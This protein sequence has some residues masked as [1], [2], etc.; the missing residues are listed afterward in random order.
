MLE[1]DVAGAETHETE[2]K[3]SDGVLAKGKPFV[4][5]GFAEGFR[6]L[7]VWLRNSV[8]KL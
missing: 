7:W 5:Q 2:H 6:S 8:V 1:D 3:P 4:L